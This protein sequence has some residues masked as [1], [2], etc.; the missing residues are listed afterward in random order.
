MPITI[1]FG[2]ASARAHGFAGRARK[3]VT[4]TITSSRTWVAPTSTNR[5]ETAGGYGAAGT[6]YDPGTPD[7]HGWYCITTVTFHKRDGSGVD[8]TASQGPNHLDGSA[9]PSNYC[10]PTV[11]YTTAQS[12]NYDYS[13][14]CYNFYAVTVAGTPPTP[15]TTGA[16]TTAFGKTFP[17]G[18]GGP[19]STTTFNSISISPGASYPISIPAGGS[20]TISYYK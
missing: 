13:T 2:S 3:L 4:E 15:A 12:A 11:F 19:A 6:P 20:L 10:D 14:T 7:Q 18:T 5:I 9:V 16:S 1:T 17:G 8:Q